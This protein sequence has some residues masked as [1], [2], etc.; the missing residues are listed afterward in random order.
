MTTDNHRYLLDMGFQILFKD[1]NISA[2]DVLRHA[3]LPLDL[4]SRK[5]PSVTAEEYL[6]LWNGL[7]YVMRDMPLFPLE[8]ALATTA[9]SFSPPIFACFC[10]ENLNVAATRLSHYKPLVGPLRLDIKQN[11]QRT[12]VACNLLPYL[13]IMPPTLVAME[14]AWWVR[15][16]RL[17][18]REH[19]VPLA[20]HS[21]IE[22][23]HHEKYE[24]YFGVG[25]QHDTFSGVS[26]SAADAARPFLTA[27][28]GMWSI[29][30]SELNMRMQDLEKESSFRDRV[31]ACLME[32][33]ASGQY[34]MSDVASRLAVSTR[35]L[36]RR[37]KAENTTFQ[38]ELDTL[39]EELARNYLKRSDYTSG[40]I[41]FLLGYEDP[42]SF[43]RAFRSW[44]GQTPEVVRASIQ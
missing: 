33:L 20:V 24:D 36:Q 29:F 9:E 16:V 2:Q 43:F 30:E 28:D 10:S 19:I 42:N 38:Q 14:L 39:R 37:L 22:I 11:S 41:A 26:F 3:Q 8:F 27:S 23:P 13:G 32:I 44:T 1:M 7:V 21:T 15:V 5:S 4:L 17:A 40:Q 31:R 35:T 25:I 34:S 6:R 12:I 18:T